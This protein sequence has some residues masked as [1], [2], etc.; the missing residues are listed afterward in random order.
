MKN[1]TPKIKT[2]RQLMHIKQSSLVHADDKTENLRLVDLQYFPVRTTK[3]QLENMPVLEKP[4][5]GIENGL[6]W[7]VTDGVVTPSTDDNLL[8][9]LSHRMKTNGYYKR[10]EKKGKGVIFRTVKK[11][12]YDKTVYTMSPWNNNV[13]KKMPELSNG[14]AEQTKT[15]IE[16]HFRKLAQ[17]G[18]TDYE[19][20]TGFTVDGVALHNEQIIHM[21]FFSMPIKKG[22]HTNPITGATFTDNV[23]C[24]NIHTNPGETGGHKKYQNAGFGSIGI[25]RYDNVAPN[26]VYTKTMTAEVKRQVQEKVT[27]NGC[28]PPDLHLAQTLDEVVLNQFKQSP[29]LL[30]ERNTQV[31]QW[32][33]WRKEV[34]AN[35]PVGQVD[36]LQEKVDI[37]RK[38]QTIMSEKLGIT[39]HN[40]LEVQMF[41]NTTARALNIENQDEWYKS[42]RTCL[43]YEKTI[44]N[45]V[46][47]AQNYCTFQ[48]DNNMRLD[49]LFNHLAKYRHKFRGMSVKNGSILHPDFA[50]KEIK[51]CQAHQQLD[52]G[53]YIEIPCYEVKNPVITAVSVDIAPAMPVK[54]PTVEQEEPV[55]QKVQTPTV[56]VQE[57]K[58]R[59]VVS[60]DI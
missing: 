51:Y 47:F 49:A 32:C 6:Y 46:V 39:A 40:P 17:I 54:A 31:L 35:S 34:V 3:K 19:K 5:Q 26:K 60:M 1:N 53:S 45:A 25:L 55:V 58:K 10:C 16:N 29:V 18:V 43:M 50:L 2:S 8:A 56:P 13:Y 15:A 28:T 22:I 14:T 36:I 41:A 24:T 23:L 21:E 11:A 44:P 38:N 30:A 59:P 48:K 42:V 4:L 20:L 27:L 52:N 37:L 12:E 9:H 7:T 57:R 33:K